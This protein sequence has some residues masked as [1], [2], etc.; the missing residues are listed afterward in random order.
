MLLR[1]IKMHEYF[2]SIHAHRRGTCEN[3]FLS[4]IKPK[5]GMKPF[6]AVK[7]VYWICKMMFSD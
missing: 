1:P 4:D 3:N 2:T 6:W 7:K 5:C